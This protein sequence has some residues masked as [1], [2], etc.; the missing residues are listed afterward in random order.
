MARTKSAPD[1]FVPQEE[2]DSPAGD[3]A[4]L[5]SM[6]EGDGP[7]LLGISGREEDRTAII[8]SR[9]GNIERAKRGEATSAGTVLAVGDDQVQ[10]QLDFGR[11][12]ALALPR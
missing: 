3:A 1:A 2:I 9:D 11:V 12:M 8:L 6:I 7:M 5:E 10:L 4:T